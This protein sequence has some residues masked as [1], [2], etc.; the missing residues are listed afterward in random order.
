MFRLTDN[1]IIT[2]IQNQDDD[3]KDH[4]KQRALVQIVS[5]HQSITKM[6][7]KIINIMQT[8]VHYLLPG[9]PYRQHCL[10]DSQCS[11]LASL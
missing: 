10:S 3:E 5:S 11:Q 7:I 4:S 1:F 9:P 6:H 2:F 8:P